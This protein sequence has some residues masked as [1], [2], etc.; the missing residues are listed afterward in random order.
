MFLLELRL[1][2]ILIEQRVEGWPGGRQVLARLGDGFVAHGTKIWY[3]G[4]EIENAWVQLFQ[5]C[6]IQS[7]ILWISVPLQQIG[8][9]K[10]LQEIKYL[11]HRHSLFIGSAMNG[12]NSHHK[13]RISIKELLVSQLF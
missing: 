10:T 11:S 2:S 4:K 5:L 13:F 7:Y 9:T 3:G 8:D 6:R 1:S 12:L